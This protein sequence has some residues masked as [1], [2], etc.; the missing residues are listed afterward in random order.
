MTTEEVVSEIERYLSYLP[1]NR[2]KV[3]VAFYG[4]SFTGIG[5]DRMESYLRSVSPYMERG[6][7]Q[8]IRI[9]TRPDYI[10]RDVLDFLLKYRVLT[11]ELGVQSMSDEV[12]DRN[13]RGHSA[14]DVRRAVRLI[15]EAGF[16][17]GIQTMI[18]LDGAEENDEMTTAEEVIFLRPNFIRIY[19]TLVLKGTLLEK[20]ML[21]GQYTPMTTEAAIRLL[22]Q[23]VP[24]YERA[25]IDI[26]RLGLYE[27]GEAPAEVCAGPRH[28]ALRQAVYSELYYRMLAEALQGSEPFE[29]L[30]ITANRSDLAY[31][32]GYRAQNKKK[33]I[34][35]FKLRRIRF[36]TDPFADGLLLE[37]NG[38][39]ER[40]NF[41]EFIRKR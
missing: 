25:E 31:A 15:Q 30:E 27:S 7:V 26:I 40:C 14:E 17:L 16:S 2:G 19:P 6:E 21:E 28:P 37:R 38:I 5:Y 41:T 10:D 22:I 18:G 24:L 33:L 1:A 8:S 36:T 20:R 35:E 9:S 11:I 39:Q 4:G 32:I 29:M 13:H 34:E 3:E 23:L 12:L